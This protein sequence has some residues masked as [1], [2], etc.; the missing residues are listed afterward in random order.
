[1]PRKNPPLSAFNNDRDIVATRYNSD[2]Q[3]KESENPSVLT[4]PI[5]AARQV[6]VR[7]NGM[8]IMMG[9]VDYALMF[10]DRKRELSKKQAE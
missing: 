8:R 1:M 7:L 5:W 6:R 2:A 10:P 9:I 4:P 3:Q